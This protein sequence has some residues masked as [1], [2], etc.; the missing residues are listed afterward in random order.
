MPAAGELVM[1]SGRFVVPGVEHALQIIGVDLCLLLLRLKG[2][3]VL[4]GSRIMNTPGIVES[5]HLF[6]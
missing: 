2:Y 1:L 3:I 4:Q 5:L 6:S